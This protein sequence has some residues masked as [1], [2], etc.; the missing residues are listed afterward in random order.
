V[1]RQKLRPSYTYLSAYIEGAD[2][3]A[4]TDNPDCI[5][6]VSFVVYKSEENMYYPIFVDKTK[7]TEKYK[8]IY[9]YT[10]DKK[11]CIE[12][13]CKVGDAMIFSGI[14]HLHFREKLNGR[15]YTILLHYVPK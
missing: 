2:L 10:P 8:G 15:Y 14:D 12:I 4:H 11:D 7:Q 13:D 3:K 6:T 1:T 5:Y 9:S